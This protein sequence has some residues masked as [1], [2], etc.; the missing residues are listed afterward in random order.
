[1]SYPSRTPQKP[2]LSSYYLTRGLWMSEMLVERKKLMQ[3]GHQ[4]WQTSNAE[5]IE[6]QNG[7]GRS[8]LHS[9]KLPFISFGS[10]GIA[11][12]YFTNIRHVCV[13][14]CT[15]IHVSSA[16]IVFQI[17]KTIDYQHAYLDKLGKFTLANKIHSHIEKNDIFNENH[18]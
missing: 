6:S 8:T 16:K 9:V 13:S 1:M 5:C 17:L 12:R 3:E 14:M 4:L 18:K 11:V 10:T 2:P 7:V 15:H